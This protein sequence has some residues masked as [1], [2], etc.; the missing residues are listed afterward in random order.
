MFQDYNVHFR[1]ER[2]LRPGQSCGWR[3]AN[4]G[5][6]ARPGRTQTGARPPNASAQRWLLSYSIIIT[7]IIIIV[8][9]SI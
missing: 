5:N 3:V 4:E 1:S 6:F 2:I 7:I 8:S 9:L